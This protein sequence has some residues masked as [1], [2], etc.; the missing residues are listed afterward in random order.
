MSSERADAQFVSRAHVVDGNEIK[1]GMSS[2]ETGRLGFLGTAVKQGC[3]ACFARA[4]REGWIS[5]RKVVLIGYDDRNEPIEAVS[6]TE[7]L[8]DHD[9]LFALLNFLGTATSRAFLPMVSESNIQ[10]LGP[11]PGVEIFR[12][13][14][15]NY[16]LDLQPTYEAK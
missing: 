1:L 10:L 11:I 3:L 7:R 5:G 15:Q 16:A 2:A 14:I 9:K 13:P 4:N 8:I 12:E 6:N